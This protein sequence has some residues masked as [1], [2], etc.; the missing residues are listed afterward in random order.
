MHIINFHCAKSS[1]Q[2][3]H[4]GVKNQQSNK[5]AEGGKNDVKCVQI[6]C[7]SLR[8]VRTGMVGLICV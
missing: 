3:M 1:H 7:A 8:L 5:Y 6:A 4:Y 2:T